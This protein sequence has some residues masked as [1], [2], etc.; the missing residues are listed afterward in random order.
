MKRKK[1]KAEEHGGEERA[2]ATESTE[3]QEAESELEQLRGERDEYLAH[4][5]RA[6][7]DYQNLRR[8][9]AEDL[10]SGVRRKLE[11]MLLDLLIVL[12]HLDMAMASP[13]ESTD[14]TNLLFG[15]ELVRKQVWTLLENAEVEAIATEGAFDPSLHQAVSRVERDGLDAE[16]VEKTIRKGYL[17][18]RRPLRFAQVEVAGPPVA[19]RAEEP[20][21]EP[22]DAS[23][24]DESGTDEPTA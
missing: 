1:K 9:A 20:A 3:G 7:A 22:A 18:Q 14:A 6:Q 21:D 12:D 17:W 23:T 8:R 16:Q 13:V 2:T 24:E 11:P 15:V 5:Q 10:E 4:W 19:A